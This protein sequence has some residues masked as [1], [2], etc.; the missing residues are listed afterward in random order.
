MLLSQTIYDSVTNK[1]NT[2]DSTLASTSNNTTSRKK[3]GFCGE[4]LH[5]RQSCLPDEVECLH[6]GI[7]DHCSK[8]CRQWLGGLKARK[9]TATQ[10]KPNLL[11]IPETLKNSATTCTIYAKNFSALIDSCSYVARTATQVAKQPINLILPFNH[12]TKM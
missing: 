9:C 10:Y 6:C 11:A 8:V 1:T 4:T 3:C 7:V 12:A 5:S 2:K